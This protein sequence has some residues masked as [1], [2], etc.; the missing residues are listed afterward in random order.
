MKSS[1]TIT[2]GAAKAKVNGD[3]IAPILNRPQTA[4]LIEII[5]G[6]DAPEI[7]DLT[8]VLIAAKE[9]VDGKG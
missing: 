5:D 7:R 3:N 2:R 8:A 4:A 9:A 6:I 1:R